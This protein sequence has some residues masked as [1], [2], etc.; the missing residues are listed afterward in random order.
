V[1]KVSSPEPRGPSFTVEELL[2]I[3][4]YGFVVAGIGM[5]WGWRWGSSRH[6]RLLRSMCVS[7]VKQQYFFWGLPGTRNAVDRHKGTW[8]VAA[9]GKGIVLAMTQ[10]GREIPQGPCYGRERAL[11]SSAD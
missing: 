5:G 11:E 3:D 10:S 1:Q 7:L 2:L 8:L 9:L 4:A 6:S